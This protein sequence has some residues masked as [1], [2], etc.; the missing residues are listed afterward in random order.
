MLRVLLLAT[1]LAMS[2]FP[3]ALSAAETYAWLQYAPSGLEARAIATGT[4][5]PTARIDGA[6]TAMAVRAGPDAAYPITVCTLAV[7]PEAKAVDI[8]GTPLTLPV[9]APKHIAILGDTGC[10]LKDTYIQACND[11]EQWPFAQIAAKIAAAKPDLIIDV[12]DYH[13]R[14]TPCPRGDKGCE[15]SPYGDNWQ[16]W[17]IDFFAP[18]APLLATAP[19]VMVRGNHEDCMRG[20][21]GWSRALEGAAFAA[22]AGCNGSSPP[23]VVKFD[24]L[25][26]AVMDVAYAS[27]ERVNA[28]QAQ[29][30]KAQYRS[31]AG[32]APTPLWILQ[33]RPIWSPGGSF[34]GLLYGDNKTLAEAAYDSLPTNADLFLSGHHHIFQVLDY[35]DNRPLQIVSGNSGDYLNTG[36]RSNPA[37]WQVN[38][39]KV[40]GGIHLPQIFGYS[41][42]DQDG[43]GW[44]ITNYDRT[45][46]PIASCRIEGRS[47]QCGE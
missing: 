31:L 24:N 43:N 33:H 13:Y 10:R 7:P 17:Q 3:A 44:R 34:A 9:K 11:P 12:G 37:G 32:V 18:A 19:W 4:A 14:E 38:G 41:L 2:A 21:K 28:K 1:G 25:A 15:N 36:A 26:L 39:A 47:A 5:C 46:A 8:G 22:A 40:K 45:G 42:I 6:E 27:E 29:D 23:Y 30:Y 35:E 20:G 16:V